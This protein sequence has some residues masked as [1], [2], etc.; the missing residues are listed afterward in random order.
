MPACK[1]VVVWKGK[2]LLFLLLNFIIFHEKSSPDKEETDFNS[3]FNTVL[4]SLKITKLA[5]NMQWN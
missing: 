4:K 2:F 1:A 3:M 5:A